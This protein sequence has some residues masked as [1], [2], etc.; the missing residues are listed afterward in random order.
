MYDYENNPPHLNRALSSRGF[1]RYPPLVDTY[2]TH[3]VQV[4]ESSAAS[5][6][7]LWVN[8]GATDDPEPRCA[9]HL[10]LEQAQQLADQLLD[11][12]QHHYKT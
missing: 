4:Y 12:I 2:G 10:T 9:A 5:E 11:A 1:A 3:E 8:V 6:P 7:C